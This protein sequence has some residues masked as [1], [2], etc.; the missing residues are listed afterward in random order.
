MQESANFKP[1]LHDYLDKI[2]MY[3]KTNSTGGVDDINETLMKWR[4]FVN[5]GP[6]IVTIS[7]VAMIL[8]ESDSSQY[9][10]F[11]LR[12]ERFA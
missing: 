11:D 10:L 4:F 9:A 1:H 12:H 7:R 8:T 6:T 3:K 2:Q 5:G